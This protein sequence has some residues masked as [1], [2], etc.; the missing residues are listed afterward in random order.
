MALNTQ[1]VDGKQALD[2]QQNALNFIEQATFSK[3][4]SYAKSTGTPS[5]GTKPNEA[6]TQDVPIDDQQPGPLHLEA[7]AVGANAT[8]IITQQLLAG[9]VV[10]FH[11]IAFVSGAEMMVLGFR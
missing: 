9:K 6:V 3:V 2:A 8:A 4:I 10:V 7:L 5:A 11:D 1:L